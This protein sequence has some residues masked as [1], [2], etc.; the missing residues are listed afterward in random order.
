M[1][2][3]VATLLLAAP[4][5]AAAGPPALCFPLDIGEARS[6]PWGEGAFAADPQY[7]VARL[8]AD[9]YDILLRSDDPFVHAETL[10]RAA[11]YLTGAGGAPVQAAPEVRA[12]ALTKL[13][14]ELEFDRAVHA[15]AGKAA[16]EQQAAAAQ[17]GQASCDQ[18]CAAPVG[19]AAVRHLVLP[20]EPAWGGR[21]CEAQSRKASLCFLDEGYLL[22][23]LRQAGAPRA[24]DG[25]AAL[26]TALALDAGNPA[27][28]LVA[29]LGL[30][31]HADAAVRAE[32]W[33]HLDTADTLAEDAPD[34][35][36]VRRNLVATAGHILGIQDH[37]R[38]VEHIRRKFAQG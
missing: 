25:T 5:P 19:A 1:L 13:L 37:D 11:V 27:L 15:A 28:R 8:P 16:R 22:A 30:M 38:L 2:A 26:R 3:L 21:V 36:R 4:S 10:R 7:D 32:G 35:A 18:P 23:A 9:T 20:V 29:G 33:R 6:L 17:A 31:E 14:A 12:E 24:D 34:G